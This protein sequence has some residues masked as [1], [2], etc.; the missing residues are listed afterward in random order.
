MTVTFPTG[1]LPTVASRTRSVLRG[2]SRFF[3]RAPLSAFWGCIAAAI[4]IMAI[5]A[6]VIAPYEPLKSDFRSMQ[7]PPDEKHWFGTDQIGRDTLSR[8]IYGSRASLIPA[9]RAV[10]L[11]PT[12]RALL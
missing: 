11:R 6:P 9:V 1:P 10:L 4:V 2:V 7:K 3:R 5:A 12:G 8:V